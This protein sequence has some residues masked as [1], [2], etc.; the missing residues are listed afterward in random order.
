MTLYK[1][2]TPVTDE[3]VKKLQ[4]GD[5]VILEGRV[6]T[7]RDQAHQRLEEQ[8]LPVE[9]GK[10]NV[11]YHCGPIVKDGK[12][13]SAGPTTSSR[14]NKYLETVFAKGVKVIIGKGGMN[15][16]LFVGKGVYLALTGGCGA[17]AAKSLD[18]AAHEWDDLPDA[19]SIWVLELKK[20]NELKLVVAIDSTGKSQFQT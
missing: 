6:F 14:M 1:L 16:E 2:Q 19:E 15:P 10:T 9:A 3:D 20:E 7:A 11:L 12:V 4:V 5:E 13:V 18:L 8:D 17:L